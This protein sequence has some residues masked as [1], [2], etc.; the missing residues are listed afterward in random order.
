MKTAGQILKEAREKSEK[1]LEHIARE[2]KIK[3]K[4]LSALENADYAVL[5]NLSVAQ[6]FARNYAQAVEAN[7]KLVT[8]LLRRDFPQRKQ[9][10]RARELS[11]SQK[12]F[13]TPRTTVFFA[14]GITVLV[15]GF[16]LIRQYALFVGAP[17]LEVNKLVVGNNKILVMGKTV[18]T[19]TIKVN[20]RGV[21]VNKDGAFSTEIDKKDVGKAVEIK[22]ISR[23]G[24]ETVIEKTVDGR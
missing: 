7:P 6:G 2:T 20:G 15:L 5:P 4:F 18:P 11:F 24:K 16:Y 8:A 21:L 13:W 17:P 14:V 22:A 3:E 19:A 12:S 23:G 9:A 10:L 1:S